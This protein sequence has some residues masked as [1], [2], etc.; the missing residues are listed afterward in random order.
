MSRFR[1]GPAIMAQLLDPR[2]DRL[3]RRHP[4]RV[5]VKRKL[6]DPLGHEHSRAVA[7]RL[8]RP[9]GSGPEFP[10]AQVHPRL[11]AER[12]V[13]RIGSPPPLRAAPY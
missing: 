1:P 12:V 9:L 11:A 4:I 7:V 8:R 2:R 13:F 3:P 6:A 5:A 10:R